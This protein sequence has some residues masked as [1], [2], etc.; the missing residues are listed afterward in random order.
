MAEWKESQHPRVPSGSEEGGQFTIAPKSTIFGSLKPGS[1]VVGGFSSKH[2]GGGDRYRENNY[3]LGV[4]SPDGVAVGIYQNS[5][6]KPSIYVGKE[7]KKRLI[8]NDAVNLSAG[9]IIGGV[10]GYIKP[11]TPMLLPE[12]VQKLGDAEVAL[13][14]VPKIKGASPREST[15]PVAALQFRRKF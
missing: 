14:Y 11:V 12:L 9:V 4:I 7:Y 3:G 8:G 13:T 15:P 1:R 2:M 6:D 5:V 10:T